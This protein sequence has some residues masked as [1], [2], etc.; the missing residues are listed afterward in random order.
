MHGLRSLL[1]KKNKVNDVEATEW[2][3]SDKYEHTQR[4]A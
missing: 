2:D 1:A 3:R 4:K